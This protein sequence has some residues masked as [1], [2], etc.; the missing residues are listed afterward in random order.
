M[1]GG[2]NT[3]KL[4]MNLCAE[5]DPNIAHVFEDNYQSAEEALDTEVEADLA[6][7]DDGSFTIVWQSQDEDGFGI[8][9]Q[10]YDSSGTTEG[11]EFLVNS[12][13]ANNQL[14]IATTGDGNSVVVVWTSNNQYGNLIAQNSKF[15]NQS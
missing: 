1:V 8:Y 11:S 2:T 14:A 9:G 13:T 7:A 5:E 15:P 4:T 3:G 12:T 6:V 10:S